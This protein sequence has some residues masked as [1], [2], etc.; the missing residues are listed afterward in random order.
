MNRCKKRK[1]FHTE[2][3]Q[4]Q[5]I[6]TKKTITNA[7]NVKKLTFLANKSGL[8]ESLLHRLDQTAGDI[9]FYTNPNTTKYTFF[10]Q[11]RTIAA[12]SCKPL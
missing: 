11:K 2:K 8:A 1:S 4:K 3:G 6:S 10:K 7:D 9:G 12:P 5:M